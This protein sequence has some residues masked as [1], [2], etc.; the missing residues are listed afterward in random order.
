MLEDKRFRE[1]YRYNYEK[2]SLD[3][4]CKM[5]N[6]RS[7]HSICYLNDSIYLIG[8]FSKNNGQVSSECEAFRISTQ[9]CE[10]IASLNAPSANSCAVAYGGNYILKFGGVL[11]KTDGNNLIEM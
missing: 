8:G 9:S 2:N 10:P 1:I 7:S 4:V 6:E 5:N 3:F 11:N